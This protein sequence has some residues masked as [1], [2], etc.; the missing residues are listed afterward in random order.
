MDASIETVY[1]KGGGEVNEDEILVGEDIYGVFDGA[2]SIHNY[3]D[4][5]GK[6]GA[7]IASE[8]A[9]QTFSENEGKLSE[10][11]KEV[12]KNLR[13]AMR[14]A[15]VNVE[16]NEETW[17]T[18]ASLVRLSNRKAEFFQIT[19][20]FIL[21]IYKDGSFSLPGKPY[22]H[23]METLKRWKM[24]ADQGEKNIREKVYSTIRKTRRRANKDYGFLNGDPKSEKFFRSGEF[25]LENVK[26]IVLG[27]DGL[28]IPKEDPS[29][30]EKWKELIGIYKEHGLE[31]VKNHVRKLEGSDPECT[32]YI[33]TKTHDDIAGIA[34]E[35]D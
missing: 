33:R 9:C 30:E 12:N 6:T 8:I 3:R 4:K 35:F 19:D 7:K 23:D 18:T 22:N 26:T 32:E 13:K 34:I 21:V 11:A 15:G 24:L 14:S 28:M 16:D 2:T 29:E 5:K 17:A 31:G 10:I 27:S 20:S 25:N 1:D